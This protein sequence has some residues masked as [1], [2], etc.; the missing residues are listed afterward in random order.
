MVNDLVAEKVSQLHDIVDVVTVFYVVGFVDHTHVVEDVVL[1]CHELQ[2]NHA[3]RPNVRLV[4]LMGMVQ[5]RLQRHVR[6]CSD[7]ISANNLQTIAQ[8]SVD[9]DCLFKLLNSFFIF[10]FHFLQFL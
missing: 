4:R 5:N 9:S 6:L 10:L 7:L 3:N 1:S 2:Q 8:S